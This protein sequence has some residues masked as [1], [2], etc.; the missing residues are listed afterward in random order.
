M[1]N[2]ERR[3]RRRRHVVGYGFLQIK[4]ASGMNRLTNRGQKKEKIFG[5]AAGKPRQRSSI[6]SN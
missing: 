3:P 2:S 4:G 6:L 5:D 1:G